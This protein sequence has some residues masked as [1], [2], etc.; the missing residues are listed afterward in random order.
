[1][2]HWPAKE[3][4]MKIA[5]LFLL[6]FFLTTFAVGESAAT[7]FSPGNYEIRNWIELPGGGSGR[8][9]KQL[10]YLTEEDIISK[11]Y[12]DSG[13]ETLSRKIIGDNL[14][15]EYKCNSGGIEGISGSI[16]FRGDSF[17]GALLYKNGKSEMKVGVRGK[18]IGDTPESRPLPTTAQK[19]DEIDKVLRSKWDAMNSYLKQGNFDKALEYFHPYVR[20]KYSMLFKELGGKMPHI[21]AAQSEFNRVEINDEG[22][23]ARYE[24]VTREKD[25]KY[26][27]GVIFEKDPQNGMWYIVDF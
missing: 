15:F 17:E 23:H 14:S 5:R 4:T 27:Y 6:T 22:G 8:A 2:P 20:K 19:L 18:R 16:T 26:S 13:C 24:S 9:E 10:Q 21:V 3:I 7:N 25:G 12:G 1:M 11:L